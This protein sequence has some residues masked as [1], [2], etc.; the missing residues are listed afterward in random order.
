LIE[1]FPHAGEAVSHPRIPTLRRVLLSHV[2]Y[3]LYY[4]VF[5]EEEIVEVLALWHTSR[6]TQPRSENRPTSSRQLNAPA[7]DCAGLDNRRHE[8]QWN[9][10]RTFHWRIR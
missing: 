9:I 2:Q 5:V 4:N 8:C 7:V 10:H 1:Q 6:Q 3:H